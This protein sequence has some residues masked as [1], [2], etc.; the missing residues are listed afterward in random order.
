MRFK[1]LF[2]LRD[3]IIIMDL[4]MWTL[5]KTWAHLT[6]WAEMSQWS[7]KLSLTDSWVL[8][9]LCNPLRVN[10]ENQETRWTVEDPTR[11][12]TICKE[13]NKEAMQVRFYWKLIQIFGLWVWPYTPVQILTFHL[14]SNINI[15]LHQHYLYRA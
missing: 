6:A 14:L 7:M 10:Q 3:T 13:T 2:E 12:L 5:V 1:F 15:Y 8:G 9:E 11:K 4:K